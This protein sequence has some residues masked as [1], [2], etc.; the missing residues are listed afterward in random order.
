MSLSGCLQSINKGKPVFDVA[1][2]QEL[3]QAA[4][5]N[6]K[7]LPNIEAE[8]AAVDAALAEALT[9]QKMVSD[10]IKKGAGYEAPVEQK[11]VASAE[12]PVEAKP[13]EAKPV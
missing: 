5:E 7:T 1:E 12:K 3:R 6:R 8:K 4:S 9:D 13:V 2:V 10:L 11:P